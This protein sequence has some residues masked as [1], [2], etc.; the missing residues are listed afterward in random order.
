MLAKL[1]YPFFFP[2]GIFFVVGVLLLKKGPLPPVV[3]PYLPL[4]FL[5]TLGSSMLLGWRFNHSRLVFAQLLIGLALGL[6]LLYLEHIQLYQSL[7][8]LL[9]LNLT[10]ILLL[11]ERGFTSPFAALLGS[12]VLLQGLGGFWLAVDWP[13]KLAD[14]LTRPLP[15]SLS[16][17]IQPGL[18]QL[19]TLT[20]SMLLALI[21]FRRRSQPL[22][23]AF[24]WTILL[25]VLPFYY[26]PGDQLTLILFSLA[27]LNLLTGQLET[28]HNMAY[29]DELTGI[30]G[31][32]ALNEALNRL[33]GSYC[34]AMLDIDHFKK[35]NDKHGH[36]VGDQV[37]KMVAARL[38]T[39]SDGGRAFRY[40][41]E[42]FAVIFPG[43]KLEV[44]LPQLETLRQKVAIAAFI[45]RGKNRPAKK[46]KKT[47][48]KGATRKAL[49]VT[50]SIGVA[51]PSRQ[52]RSSDQVMIAAD[53]A[54]Y[55]AKQQGRN[56][57]CH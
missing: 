10:L 36:E 1:F 25:A 46:P 27:S 41:G 6:C 37:L 40:G 22:E 18:F 49:S 21:C 53:Q 56:R 52:H 5:L 39:V 42:E 45:P 14:L 17:S 4:L 3:E 24:F 32:R 28:S 48:P 47:T 12:A 8:L 16:L 15:T 35:F 51:E 30:P 38:A 7:A 11:P 54:L 13:K 20:T 31:R 19:G 33:G 29:R 34:L 57:V 55:R 50:I 26:H 44:A 43:S 23:A 9:P 2:G